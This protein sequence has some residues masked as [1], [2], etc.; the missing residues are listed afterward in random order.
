MTPDEPLLYHYN[1]DMVLG[2]LL[3]EFPFPG[4]YYIL[5]L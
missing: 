2:G 5:T 1:I 3:A 4:R